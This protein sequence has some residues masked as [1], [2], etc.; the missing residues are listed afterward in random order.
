LLYLRQ[1]A[2]IQ[3]AEDQN[4]CTL[5]NVYIIRIKVA[6]LIKIF[7]IL[8]LLSSVVVFN[9]DS[10][11]AQRRREVKIYLVA[12][13]DNGKMGRKIGCEDSLVPVTRTIRATAAPLKDAIQELL[14]TPAETGNNPTLKNFWIGRNLRVKSVSLRRST[15]TIYLSGEVFVAGVCDEPRIQSQIEET[16]RQFANVKRVKIFLGKRT[17]ADAIR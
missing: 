17:L 13:N 8:V 12:L 4:L 6:M 15:A 1:N 7:S 2:S 11:M 10:V 3:G 14:S 16:A 9:S 5:F